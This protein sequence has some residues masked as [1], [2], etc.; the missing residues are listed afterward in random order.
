M[1]YCTLTIWREILLWSH[2]L[3]TNFQWINKIHGFLGRDAP[4]KIKLIRKLSF[5]FSDPLHILMQT[6]TK[7]DD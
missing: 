2:L 1:L 6:V 5:L 3:N 4:T 7:I